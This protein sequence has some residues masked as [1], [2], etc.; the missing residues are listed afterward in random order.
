LHGPGNCQ[1]HPPLSQQCLRNASE[2][3]LKWIDADYDIF[4]AGNGSRHS[5]AFQCARIGAVDLSAGR[6]RLSDSGC[7]SPAIGLQL[8][9]VHRLYTEDNNPQEVGEYIDA[10]ASYAHL[11]FAVKRHV[12]GKH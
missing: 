6:I 1:R 7:L 9:K 3:G 2:N 11:Q 10:P 8:L 4:H 12:P 5:I